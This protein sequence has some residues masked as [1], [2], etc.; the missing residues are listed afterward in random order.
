MRSIFDYSC[1]NSNLL[2]CKF[3]FRALFLKV[4]FNLGTSKMKFESLRVVSLPVI[5]YN[6][7]VCKVSGIES[8]LTLRQS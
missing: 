8:T 7:H 4:F 6:F 1:F 5:E 2:K 3:A